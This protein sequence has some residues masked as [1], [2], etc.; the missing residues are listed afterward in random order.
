MSNKHDADADT[1]RQETLTNGTIG[2]KSPFVK[3]ASRLYQWK[4]RQPIGM[5]FINYIKCASPKAQNAMSIPEA[6]VRAQ[7]QCYKLS[8]M[9][10]LES[11]LL[12]C[13]SL[14][15]VKFKHENRDL[16]CWDSSSIESCNFLLSHYDYP[17]DY[18]HV[19]SFPQ[20]SSWQQLYRNFFDYWMEKT[21]HRSVCFGVEFN[22]GIRCCWFLRS[23][24]ASCLCMAN[25]GPLRSFSYI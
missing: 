13:I 8:T 23:V 3:E 19:A 25:W 17:L 24:R 15:S 21:C 10:W 14:E 5:P 9:P 1:D 11:R 7:T 4:R 16:N 2:K 22:L 18:I 12:Q 6:S 20:K